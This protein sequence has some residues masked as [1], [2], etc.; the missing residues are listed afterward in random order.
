M[1]GRPTGGRAML[2]GRAPP[3]ESARG[4]GHHRVPAPVVLAEAG[5]SI[6]MS[7]SRPGGTLA[8]EGQKQALPGGL[9]SGFD[10]SYAGLD[11]GPRH[12]GSRNWIGPH[13]F[14]ARVGTIRIATGGI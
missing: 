8:P 4:H 9:A 5:S 7:K 2:V 12:G 14:L 13:A 1:V 11:A 3:F 10:R 6:N